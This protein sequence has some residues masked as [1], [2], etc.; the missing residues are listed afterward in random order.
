MPAGADRATLGGP[1]VR[2]VDLIPQ[3][4]LRQIEVGGDL[5]N[6]AITDAGETH[7]FCLEIRIEFLRFLRA[8]N[9]S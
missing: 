2:L 5:L 1:T 6:A 9:K 7:R 8:M 3:R 4:G